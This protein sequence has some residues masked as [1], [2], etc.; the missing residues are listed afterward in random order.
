MGLAAVQSET[1][2]KPIGCRSV[3]AP[4]RMFAIVEGFGGVSDWN[5]RGCCKTAD[6][7]FWSVAAVACR[8]LSLNPSWEMIS[9]RFII[10]C[11]GPET[12][13]QAGGR[14]CTR[15]SPRRFEGLWD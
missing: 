6:R 1:D 12:S 14:T 2:L 5:R 7:R 3:R 8:A 4:E 15:T 10:H 13:I 11:K 9:H